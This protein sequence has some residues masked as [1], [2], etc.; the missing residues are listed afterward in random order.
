MLESAPKITN[1]K[2]AP[3]ITVEMKQSEYENILK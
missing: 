2:E 3:K 1:F